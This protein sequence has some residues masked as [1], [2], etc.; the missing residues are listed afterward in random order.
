LGWSRSPWPDPTALWHSRSAVKGGLN[1][2]RYRNPEVDALIDRAV[3][4]IPDEERVRLFRRIHEQINAD[5]PYTFLTEN[6][7]TL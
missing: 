6:N 2:V 1:L 5:Q 4:S 3:R 7:H